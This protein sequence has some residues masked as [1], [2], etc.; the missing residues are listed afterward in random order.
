MALGN[1]KSLIEMFDPPFNKKQGL[2]LLK[3]T[4]DKYNTA[5]EMRDDGLSYE[6]IGKELELSTMTVYRA[7]NKQTKNIGDDYGR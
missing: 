5:L 7:L 1:E 3:M 4:E 6:R 2:A